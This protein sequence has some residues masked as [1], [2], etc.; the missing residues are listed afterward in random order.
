MAEP[1]ARPSVSVVIPT[2]NRAEHAAAC[3]KRLLSCTGFREIVVVDQSDADT[4]ATAIDALADARVRCVRSELRGATNGRN[5]GIEL[6]SGDV[7]AF[8]DDDCRVALDW[9]EKIGQVFAADADAA[10]VCGRVYV[11]EELQKDGFAIGFEPQVREWQHRFPPPDR[12]WG[13]TANL[14][15]RRSVFERLGKFDPLLGPGAPLRCGEEPD[16]LFR[17]LKAGLK[18]INARE[19]EVAHLGV[20]GHGAES[21]ELWSTYGV[22]TSAALFKHI[23]LGDRDAV[24]LYLQHLGIMG[25]VVTKNLLTGNRPTGLRYTW[26]FLSGTFESLKF[27]VDRAE[28]LYVPPRSR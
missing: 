27:R 16:L 25:R 3:V 23:R 11:P 28:R 13:I 15:A 7:I 20:R 19:V 9:V 10:V 21:A 14:S 22:G 8:T 26:A 17:V 18:V 6:S 5:V 1:L 24:R 2:R 12:D 4:T